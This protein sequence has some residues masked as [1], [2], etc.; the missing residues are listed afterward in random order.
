[1]SEKF[2]KFV[3]YTLDEYI[4][5]SWLVGRYFMTHQPLEAI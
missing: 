1:M 5:Q 4:Q 3:I 2:G